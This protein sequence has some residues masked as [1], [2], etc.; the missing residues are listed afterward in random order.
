MPMDASWSIPAQLDLVETLTY[1]AA[2]SEKA[3]RRF[4]I[5]IDGTCERLARMP[6]LGVRRDVLGFGIRSYPVGAYLILYRE[7][8]QGIV[9]LRL[10]HGARN[11]EAL[12]GTSFSPLIA[13][14]FEFSA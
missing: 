11:I 4:R 1:I 8:E 12:F 5:V 9:V 6:R 10:L 2:D 3:A 13:S 14:T 7:C